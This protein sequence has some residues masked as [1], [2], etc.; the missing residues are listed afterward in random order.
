MRK[1]EGKGAA[2]VLFCVVVVREVSVEAHARRESKGQVGSDAD[3][4][5]GHC[6]GA[7]RHD[8][9]VAPEL[10][11]A[12]DLWVVQDSL[13]IVQVRRLW[14]VA[15]WRRCLSSRSKLS[16]SQWL[17]GASAWQTVAPRYQEPPSA[18]WLAYAS[19]KIAGRKKGSS[20]SGKQLEGPKLP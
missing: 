4:E 13:E 8:N 15:M 9:Q 3:E 19:V 16:G 18:G 20:W 6:R 14:R 2:R 5:G 7:R 11:R 1:G 10:L 12:L 17:P